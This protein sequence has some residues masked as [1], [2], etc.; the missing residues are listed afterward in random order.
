MELKQKK[1]F[2][3]L[4][5]FRANNFILVTFGRNWQNYVEYVHSLFMF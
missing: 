2:V 1:L 5:E 4:D 3:R